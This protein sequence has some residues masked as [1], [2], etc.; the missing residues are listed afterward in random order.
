MKKP[1]TH[2]KNI[3]IQRYVFILRQKA[4]GAFTFYLP[5]KAG[6]PPDYEINSI[7]KKIRKSTIKMK[8]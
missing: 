4:L 3:G 1:I 6:L 5:E 7:D 2:P 8:K